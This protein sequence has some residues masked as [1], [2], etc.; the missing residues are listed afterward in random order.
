MNVNEY[1]EALGIK[2]EEPIKQK[3]VSYKIWNCRFCDHDVAYHQYEYEPDLVYFVGRQAELQE[4]SSTDQ[5][6][7]RCT[8]R[9][10]DCKHTYE[11]YVKGNEEERRMR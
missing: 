4:Y 9:N 3:K 5:G 8:H 11:V 7:V 2:P 1:E 10:C 6:I